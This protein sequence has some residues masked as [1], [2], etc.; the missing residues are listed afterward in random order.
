MN[1][2]LTAPASTRPCLAGIIVVERAD[3]LAVSV[4]ASLLAELGAKIIRIGG[5]A[6]NIGLTETARGRSTERYSHGKF[7]AANFS[8]I[9]AAEWNTWVTRAD[10][11]LVGHRN[12]SDD[13]IFN[14]EARNRVICVVSTFGNNLTPENRDFDEIALQAIGG[15]MAATGQR[16]G[17]PQLTYVPII[18]MIT[19]LNATSGILAALRTRRGGRVEASG[20]DSAFA[21]LSTYVATV[22]RG[23]HDGYR[24]GSGHHL[25]SPWNV[26]KTSDGWIQ[27]CTTTNQHWHNLLQAIGRTDLQGDRRL[28]T[29]DD[30][31][32]NSNLVEE[33]IVGWTSARTTS[34]SVRTLDAANLPVGS[35]KTVFEADLASRT[36]PSFGRKSFLHGFS[37]ASWLAE[38]DRNLTRT[39]VVPTLLKKR[40]MAVGASVPNGDRPLSGIKVIEIGA[41]TAGP[42]G[43]RYLADL[44][45]EVV[46]VESVGGEVSRAWQPQYDGHG[47]YFATC[48]SGKSSVIIDVK[49]AD[50]RERFIDLVRSADVVI[51]SLR[52]GALD[53]VNVGPVTL[54]QQAPKLIYCSIS[55]FGCGSA[56]RPALDSVIQAESGLMELVGGSSSPLRVG[57]S[58]ADQAAAHAIPLVVLAALRA[59]DESGIGQHIDLSMLDILLWITEL[60]RPDGARAIRPVSVLAATDGW[61]VVGSEIISEST[62]DKVS[63][64][65][66]SQAVSHFASIRIEAVGVFEMGEVFSQDLAHKRTLVQFA[67]TGRGAAVPILSAPFRFGKDPIPHGPLP[68]A[69]GVDTDAV[70]AAIKR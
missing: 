7:N 44:G 16:N 41:Y 37:G 35:V 67:S 51:E 40:S 60:A 69:P 19:A 13:E 42:L 23:R 3:R 17:P 26:Y 56:G 61:V 68:G 4:C 10:V 9:D 70:L 33:I 50:G 12:A 27:L 21:L 22:E 38:S 28:S 43:G 66:R 49:S 30:R 57:I 34:E 47:A 53:K 48:N 64:M 54:M 18:E 1:R 63:G 25:C 2:D 5:E 46:K 58:I 8:N 32:R 11:V 45:A 55:G 24:L 20:I 14:A 59:R 6:R 29:S 31:V 36:D 65:S 15:L 52:P 39:P 62:K